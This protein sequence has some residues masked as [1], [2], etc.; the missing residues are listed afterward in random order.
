[1]QLQRY[2]EVIDACSSLIGLYP[3]DARAYFYRG[4]AYYYLFDDVSACTDW[5]VAADLGDEKAAADYTK[6]CSQ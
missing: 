5:K 4:N 3:N 2:D 1:M 6:Y